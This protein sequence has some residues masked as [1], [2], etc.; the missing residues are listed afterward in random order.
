[1]KQKWY[2]T[3]KGIFGLVLLFILIF[4]A[5]KVGRPDASIFAGLLYFPFGLAMFLNL[6]KGIITSIIT[7]AWY[8]LVMWLC[9][10]ISHVKKN[11]KKYL[12][13]LIILILLTTTGCL[14][15]HTGIFF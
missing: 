12:I 15:G 14:F 1:M 9:Y 10:K 3:G 4:S 11:Y 13:A 7:I 6:D 5:I 8:P 2:K